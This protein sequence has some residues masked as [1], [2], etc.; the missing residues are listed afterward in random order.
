MRAVQIALLIISIQIGM[1]LV[2]ESGLFSGSFYEN[3]ITGIDISTNASALSDTEQSQ[4]S[5]NIMNTV[6]NVL[7]WGWIKDFFQPYYNLDTGVKTFIDH[8]ILLMNSVSAFIIGI[9]F[10]EFV[11][12]RVDVLG[13]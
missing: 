1:G 4:T 7:A 13:G 10:I 3:D 9:A 6:F 2:V 12:N 11:R 5:I 8:L